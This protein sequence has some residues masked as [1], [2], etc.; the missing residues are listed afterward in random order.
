MTVA[1]LAIAVPL[2]RDLAFGEEGMSPWWHLAGLTLLVIDVC[3]PR[4][5][6]D[7]EPAAEDGN[8]SP[9]VPL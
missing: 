3:R 6:P 1:F 7:A 2:G 8:P 4:P 9:D 5:K